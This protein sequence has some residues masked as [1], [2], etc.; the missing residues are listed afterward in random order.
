[1]R[2]FLY[3]CIYLLVCIIFFSCKR[4][5]KH[6]GFKE[7]ETG[8]FYKLN[9]IGD[10]KIHPQKGDYLKLNIAYKTIKDSLFLDTKRLNALGKLIIPF[11]TPSFRGS[12]E[13]HFS[14]LNEG[15][16]ATY[17]VNADSL[18]LKFLKRKTPFFIDTIRLVKVNLKLEK[19]LSQQEYEL[20]LD[21]FNQLLNDQDME[22]QKQ[23]KLYLDKSAF[24]HRPMGDGM[25]YS[26]LDTGKGARVETNKT[27][28]LHYKSFFLD[29]R[30]AEYTRKNEPLEV[31]MGN[32]DQLIKGL[33]KGIS[34]MR[35]GGKAKFIIPSQLAFGEK[36]SSTGIIPAYT[37]L[38]YEV[39]IVQVK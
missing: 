10:G 21:Q 30:L 2:L 24:Y 12:F 32:E 28:L 23:L 18:F 8:L 5:E 39:E 13:E 22:E 3:W 1:M 16:S 14:K 20:E 7:T 11:S 35:E 15:D 34:L 31:V 9:A 17:L 37:S 26:M 29:G 4:E 38:I 25:Y 6:N 19:I 33:E 36:G 27:V